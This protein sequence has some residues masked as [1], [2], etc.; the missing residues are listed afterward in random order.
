MFSLH[1]L[2]LVAASIVAA[3]S[4]APTAT[5]PP[6]IIR[7]VTSDRTGEALSR[8]VR[9]TFVVTKAE[10]AREGLRTVADALA[11]VPGIQL[12][13]Y[14]AFGAG[15]SIS[16]RGSSSSQV[17]VLV[18]GLPAAGA[19]TGSLDL[20]NFSTSG[21][22]RIEVVE[23]GGSTLYGSSA[24]G[25]V[26]NI[27]TTNKGQY[28]AL[29]SLASFGT[30]VLRV[31]TPYV[32]IG[33][34]YA[35]NDY[36]LPGGTT[37]Q[38]AQAR[39][40]TLLLHDARSI[41]ALDVAASYDLSNT[42][43][44]VPGE[45]TAFSPTTTLNEVNQDARIAFTHRLR[46]AQTSLDLGASR[47][48][49]TDTCDTAVDVNC[50]NSYVTPLPSTFSSLFGESRLALALRNVN[51]DERYRLI[52]GFD[53]SRAFG[54]LQDGVDPIVTK[55]ASQTAIYGQS[56]W[57]ARNGDSWY[58][59]ARGESDSGNGSLSPSAGLSASLAP[60][61]RLKLNASTAFRAP[62][63]EELYFPNAS[64]PNL[65]PEHT[66]NA[67]ATI[68]D[69]A[70][71]GGTSLGWF[72]TSGSNLIVFDLATFM[73]QN[74]GHASI[75]GLTFSTKTTPF[76]GVVTS[77]DVTNL[78]RAQDLQ[79]NTRLDG[80]GPVFSARLA[81]TYTAPRSSHIDGFGISAT[82][83]GARGY[84]DPTAPLY[85]QPA[86]YTRIDAYLGYRITPHIILAVRGYNLG[87]DR[88]AEFGS[89]SPTS[90]A[91]DLYPMPGRSFGLELRT[92]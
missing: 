42:E 36:A 57:F 29:A 41:G 87:N 23:G 54:I 6:Q 47:L 75:A 71:L 84:V 1:A 24:I 78:Y 72:T 76:N 46:R 4:P 64:N 22:D 20:Q 48:N 73:P 32:S 14:G 28:G 40:N 56:Q 77:L 26:V 19:Q 5:P 82:T 86:A 18:D 60:T 89:F 70:L 68:V 27:I 62:N 79:N 92:K 80:R 38:N 74:I 7:V 13:S 50:P 61:L 91:Y 37:R 55:P 3:A 51:G 39:Q 10:M 83:Q 88:Y 30:S 44:G 59:G 66:R 17:L 69:S 90:E 8:A 53:A 52:Y 81:L 11:Q 35:L 49:A 43:E 16:I 65:V 21:L 33:Q 12:Q 85:D 45:L 34:T 9:T 63:L 31:D 15:T 2:P 25:G 58:I 67:D